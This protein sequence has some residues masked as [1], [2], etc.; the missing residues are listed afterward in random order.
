M[1]TTTEISES[2][3]MVEEGHLVRWNGRTTPQVVIQVTDSWFEV[4]SHQ[5]SYYR[6]Y[7]KG[8][9]LV[10]QQS[11]TEYDVDEFEIVGEAYDIDS[12]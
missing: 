5:E 12:W 7:P 4:K 10:N 1:P 8:R 3:E 2:M 11:N 9:Y 6:F